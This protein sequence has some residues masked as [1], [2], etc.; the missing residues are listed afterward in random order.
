MEK[1]RVFSVVGVII[2][3]PPGISWEHIKSSAIKKKHRL[4]LTFLSTNAC[5]NAAIN[6]SILKLW[7]LSDRKRVCLHVVSTLYSS[8]LLLYVFTLVFRG[9]PKAENLALPHFRSYADSAPV[10]RGWMNASDPIRSDI[11]WCLCSPRCQILIGALFMTWS[12][13][14]S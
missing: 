11:S 5:S 8:C 2:E 10:E 13:Y 14:P 3:F 7:T 6:R 1:Q 9:G 12:I 4:P